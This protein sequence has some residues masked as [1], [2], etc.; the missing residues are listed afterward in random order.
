MKLT[1]SSGFGNTSIVG[2]VTYRMVGT[3]GITI[4]LGIFLFTTPL[5]R[6]NIPAII[7]YIA[8]ASIVIGQTPTQRA[9]M[10]NLY[11]IVVKKPVRQVVSTITTIDRLGHGVKMIEF[12][13]DLEVPAFKMI[14]GTYALV[15]NVTS[16]IT[17]WSE[18]EE[19]QSQ[20]EKIKT[21]FNILEGGEGLQIVTKKDSDTGMLQLA[22]HLE[23]N[24]SFEGDDLQALSDYRRTLLRNVATHANGRSVQQYAILKVRYKNLNVT[25]KAL[26]QASRVIT[27]ATNPVDVLL[28][29]M[30]L[31][32]GVEQNNRADK[33]AQTE[34]G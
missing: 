21:L 29:A 24:E 28:S 5:F 14:D 19:Y 9:I 30:G 15:Y 31:E 33:P 26:S 1:K 22:K 13:D 11:G 20:A 4:A 8:L 27:P 17:Q 25:R 12:R 34:K 2:N 7:A 16:G 3:Y 10:W 18:A 6:W 32:G 23:E